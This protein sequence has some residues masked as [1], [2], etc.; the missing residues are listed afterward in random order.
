MQLLKNAILLLALLLAQS[1]V[2][3]SGWQTLGDAHAS[4]LG[5]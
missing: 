4:A 3:E 1:M 2:A 5:G